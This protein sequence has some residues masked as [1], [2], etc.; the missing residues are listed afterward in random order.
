MMIFQ[1]YIYIYIF[2]DKIL[3]IKKGYQYFIHSFHNLQVS[4]VLSVTLKLR[5]PIPA[6]VHAAT[7][8]L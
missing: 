2:K 5:G 1:K 3:H 4:L 7:E 8:N 6:D